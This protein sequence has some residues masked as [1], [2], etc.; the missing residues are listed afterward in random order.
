MNF[1]G[2]ETDYANYLLN[3]RGRLEDQLQA[4]VTSADAEITKT[5]AALLFLVKYGISSDDQ[6]VTNL[7]Y[8]LE[9]P[10]HLPSSARYMKA[11]L[12]QGA[13]ATD[14]KNYN[15]KMVSEGVN[16]VNDLGRVQNLKPGPGLL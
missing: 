10:L 13:T 15:V 11:M 5:R 2:F 3:D 7:G 16:L 6:A 4:F 12:E 14:L 1:D 8:W 9:D